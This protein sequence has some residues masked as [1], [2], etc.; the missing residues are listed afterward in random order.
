MIMFDIY[1]EGLISCTT[2]GVS[3]CLNVCVCCTVHCTMYNLLYFLS[4]LILNH[5]KIY[6]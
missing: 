4:D 2:F 1:M 3:V 6:I 5:N